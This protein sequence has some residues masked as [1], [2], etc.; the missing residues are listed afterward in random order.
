MA[1]Q[2]APVPEQPPLIIWQPDHSTTQERLHFLWNNEILSDFIFKVGE[3]QLN[4]PAHKL[5]L[6]MTSH[7]FYNIFYLLETNTNELVIPEVTPDVFKEFL[8]YFYKDEVLLTMENVVD[9]LK[10]SKKLI[11]PLLEAKCIIFLQENLTEKR[12]Y[13]ILE[14][15]VDCDFN[16]LRDFC[17]EMIAD[18]APEIFEQEQFKDLKSSLIKVILSS[19]YFFCTEHD[20]FK[21]TLEWGISNCKKNNLE[22][23]NS[24]IRETLGDLIYFIRFPAMATQELVK[25]IS[26]FNFLTNEEIGIIFQ[27]IELKDKS[28]EKFMKSKR[29]GLSKLENSEVIACNRFTEIKEDF[30]MGGIVNVLFSVEQKIF[31]LGL[32]FYGR[33]GAGCTEYGKQ[34]EVAINVVNHGSGQLLLE[35]KSTITYD[36]SNRLYEILFKKPLPFKANADYKI[37]LARQ[38]PVEIL[39]NYWGTGNTANY[40]IA[41]TNF[42][43]KDIDGNSAVQGNIGAIFFKCG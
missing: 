24:S 11:V 1:E 18:N 6:S 35:Q 2:V 19:E 40:T 20:M 30:S 15:A 10:L 4:I 43:F 39:K 13:E 22:V 38:G 34:E 28:T 9:I 16:G 3:P 36:G 27:T 5:I 31:C 8:K 29:E 12:V 7:F 21:A 37:S 17:L 33:T 26:E 14:V 25:C 42:T 32:S 41:G 23:N